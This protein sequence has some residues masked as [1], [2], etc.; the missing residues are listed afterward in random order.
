M[1]G[2]K[3]FG[4]AAETEF[5]NDGD[6][7]QYYREAATEAASAMLANDFTFEIL[8]R[9]ICKEPNHTVDDISANDLWSKM[10]RFIRDNHIYRGQRYFPAN[11]QSLSRWIRNNITAMEK[12]GCKFD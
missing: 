6:F 11:G 4:I 10:D 12:I 5:A 7:K 1:I 3:N 2:F 8:A 9:M